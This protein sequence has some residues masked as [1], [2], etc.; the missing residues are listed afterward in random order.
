MIEKKQKAN[1]I[2]FSIEPSQLKVIIQGIGI[3]AIRGTYVWSIPNGDGTSSVNYGDSISYNEL[4]KYQKDVP[5][6]KPASSFIVSTDYPSASYSVYI[7]N[8]SDMIPQEIKENNV[9][10]PALN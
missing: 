9:A 1:P 5:T 3:E 7:I 10:I 8:N 4:I 6:V 2:Y